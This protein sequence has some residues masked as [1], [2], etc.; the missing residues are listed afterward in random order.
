MHLQSE[1]LSWCTPNQILPLRART[2]TVR[3]FVLTSVQAAVSGQPYQSCGSSVQHIL[4]KKISIFGNFLLPFCLTIF[5]KPPVNE[6]FFVTRTLQTGRPAC[7]LRNVFRVRPPSLYILCKT[8]RIE[9]FHRFMRPDQLCVPSSS[10]SRPLR[11]FL[12]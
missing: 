3:R 2:Q 12:H 4:V 5:K 10:F 7:S 9:I 11:E 1:R 6:Y 8:L